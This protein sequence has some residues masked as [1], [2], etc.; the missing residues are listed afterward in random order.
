MITRQILRSYS[1]TLSWYCSCGPVVRFYTY[2]WRESLMCVRVGTNLMD[3]PS[4]HHLPIPTAT[5]WRT[6]RR[7]LLVRLFDCSV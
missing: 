2:S 6:V 5:R 3:Q 7:T 1:C 4:A